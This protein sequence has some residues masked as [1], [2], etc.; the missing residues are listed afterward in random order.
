MGMLLDLANSAGARAG[1]GATKAPIALHDDN[2]PWV[3]PMADERRQRVLAMLEAHP[4]ARYALVTDE[5][6]DPEAVLVTLA[7]RGQATCEL[8]IPRGKYD[9]VL[10]LDLIERHG[11]TMH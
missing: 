9:G 4:T 5:R 10:L 7:I 2:K 1:M 8:A 6:A 3:D 11:A